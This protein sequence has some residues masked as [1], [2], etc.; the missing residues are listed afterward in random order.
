MQYKSNIN[1][2]YR[3]WKE[4][5]ENHFNSKVSAVCSNNR[6]EFINKILISL[7]C[8]T[9]A[10]VELTA[11]Y[12][13]AQN[14]VAERSIRILLNAVHSILFDTSLPEYCFREVLK[15]VCKLNNY[16]PTS[17]NSDQCPYEV[18]FQEDPLLREL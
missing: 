7:Y 15:T 18:L 11:P 17:A 3:E 1:R 12:N 5:A 14:R 9:G 8:A 13:P 2:F 10:D 6:G 16:S 4:W